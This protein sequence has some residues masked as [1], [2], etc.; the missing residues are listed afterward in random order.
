MCSKRLKR[1]H[2][3]HECLIQLE[4]GSI[5]RDLTGRL[6]TEILKYL[7]YDRQQIPFPMTNSRSLSQLEEKSNANQLSSKEEQILRLYKDLDSIFN[8]VIC[9]LSLDDIRV[10]C[11]SLSMGQTLQMPKELYCIEM[12]SHDIYNVRHSS[13]CPQQ[14]LRSAVTRFFKT[15]LSDVNLMSQSQTDITPIKMFVLIKVN[16]RYVKQVLDHSSSCRHLSKTEP[17]FGQPFI[18]HIEYD[19]PK[20]GNRFKLILRQKQCNCSVVSDTSFQ[21]YDENSGQHIITTDDN[22]L[23]QQLSQTMSDVLTFKE[24][25]TETVKDF[26]DEFIWVQILSSIKG[27]QINSNKSYN[28]F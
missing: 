5:D 9:F 16:K 4:N 21:I 17:T 26:N 6:V 3:M 19:I 15:I 8:E 27:I 24:D 1:S 11:V 23:D 22:H 28:N 2:E 7:L 14:T 12:P 18:P 25:I 10:E 20:F 13:D